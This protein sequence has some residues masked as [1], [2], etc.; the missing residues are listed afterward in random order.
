MFAQ[1]SPYR[2]L[3]SADQPMTQSF[4]GAAFFFAGNGY[5]SH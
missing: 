4:L 5:L 1:R 3:R 2:L